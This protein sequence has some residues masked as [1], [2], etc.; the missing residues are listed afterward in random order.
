MEEMQQKQVDILGW[1]EMNI[2]WTNIMM[3]TAFYL[4]KNIF[5][6]DNV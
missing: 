2:N 4:G 5:K 3:G 6:H 1:T